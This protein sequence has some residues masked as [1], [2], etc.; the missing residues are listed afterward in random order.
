VAS[1][2]P[3]PEQFAKVLRG[4]ENQTYQTAWS[5]PGRFYVDDEWFNIEN[6]QLF[7]QQWVCVGRVEELENPGDF[8]TCEIAGQ[9]LLLTHGKDG[10]RRALSNICLHRGTIL[11]EESGSADR[12]TCPYH[13][14]SYDAAGQ[15]LTAPRM[16]GRKDFTS[17]ECRLPEYFIE[18]WM[19]F[20]FVCI[21]SNPKDLNKQLQKATEL[22]QPYH[23]EE[24]KTL[25]RAD[26][27]WEVNWKC[28]LENFME[29]YHL[30]PLHRTTLHKVNPTRLCK[31]IEPGDIHFG[32][33]VGFTSR[34]PEE[35]VG[36]SDLTEEQMDTCVMVAIAP[37][38]AIGI[39]SDYCSF[40]CLQPVSAGRVKVKIGLLFHGDNWP[41]EVVAEAVS[42]FNDTMAEDKAVLLRVQKGLAA[43]SHAPG[44]LAKKDFE[45][46]IFDF[47][48]YLS[49]SLL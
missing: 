8:F 20:I 19:G 37:G 4:V 5:L 13:H 49:K 1:T 22:I 25:Y 48:R 6:Q 40:L 11:V 18:D 31:H 44:P 28:L 42:L 23:L 14:W 16:T 26:E 41:D 3:I 39:G 2:M 34:L 17:G 7:A 9:P 36:H 12:F 21:G 24:M 10:K 47:F 33:T 32:Y 29:G 38:L 27:C 15:L 46:T 30:S 43:P 45:G 35:R